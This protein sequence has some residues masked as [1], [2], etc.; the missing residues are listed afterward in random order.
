M[1]EEI[2]LQLMRTS[3]NDI[4]HGNIGT[5]QPRKEQA[6]SRTS[7]D[8]KNYVTQHIPGQKNKHLV[9][10]K[11]KVTDVNEQVRRR[12]WTWAG[13]C[14]S[15]PGNPT[16]RKDLHEDRRDGRQTNYWTGTIGQCIAHDRLMWMRHAE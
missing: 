13:H 2:S 1:L 11:T 5:H 4:R 3:S 7:K 14:V 15:P 16:N 10:E 12:K 9:R 6:S 8:G